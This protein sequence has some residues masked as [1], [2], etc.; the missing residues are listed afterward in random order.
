MN[1]LDPWKLEI[2]GIIRWLGMAVFILGLILAFGALF[3]LKGVENINFLATTGVY[4]KIRHPMYLGF[5][6][7]IMGWT[8]Y[9]GAIFSLIP[10]IIAIANIL[11]WRSLEDAALKERYGKIYTEYSKKTLF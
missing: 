7:W 6:F 9:N 11:Y 10:G 1:P 2:P 5:I 8:L 4:S 3:K